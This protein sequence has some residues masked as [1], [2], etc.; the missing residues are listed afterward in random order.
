MRPKY[1]EDIIEKAKRDKKNVVIEIYG[2]C[3]YGISNLPDGC[4]YTIVDHDVLKE[5]GYEYK[6]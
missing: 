3:F 5:D 4:S 6:E 2:G 1:I